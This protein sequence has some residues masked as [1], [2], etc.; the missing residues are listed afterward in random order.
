M[1]DNTTFVKIMP[2]TIA[3]KHRHSNKNLGFSFKLMFD[4]SFFLFQASS[5]KVTVYIAAVR[6]A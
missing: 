4:F 5:F 1:V 3:A 6:L 2:W